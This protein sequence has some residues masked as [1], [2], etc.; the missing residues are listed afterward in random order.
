MDIKNQEEASISSNNKVQQ[1]REAII[2]AGG[3]GTRLKN[4]VP[5]LPK[6]LANVAGR[7]F[8][9]YVINYL[10]MQ[11]IEKIIFSLGYKHDLILSW[12][13][14]AYPTLDYDYVVEAAPLGT[15]GAI[16]FALEKTNTENILV[17]NG[18][19]LYNFNA[20]ALYYQHSNLKSDCT[21]A[22]KPMQ[23]FDRYGVVETN[24][25]N[26]IT[27]F[28]EKQFY[29]KGFI[30]AGVYLINKKKFLEKEFPKIFSFEKNYLERFV[31][32]QKFSGYVDD[33][34]FIDIGIPEDYKKAQNE[35][36][37][38]NL[39]FKNIDFGWTLFLD[40]DGVI[41]EDKPG[42]YITTPQEFVFTLGAPYLFKT[43][44]KK[45]KRIIVVTNQRGVGRGIIKYADLEA[46]HEKMKQEI[47]DTGGRI[48]KIYF[49]TDVE[50][51]SICR[52]PNP[53]MALRALEDFPKID[54]KKSIMVGNSLSDMK[55]GRY[56][57]MFTVF[58]QSTNKSISQPNADIDLIFE[59]LYDFTSALK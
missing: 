17:T 19:T 49:C 15:G 43:L 18:D 53:G 54:F 33:V 26:V 50:D 30:N 41:N 28:K 11:G 32:D 40:R 35:L 56:A 13:Q 16:Q 37:R 20:S 22:L 4:A 3:L 10:R 47:E 51:I 24:K 27:S 2:L 46:M 14:E 55:F 57:G 45:F 23:D 12:L 44:S 5:D 9:Y 42:G 8:L 48:D 38:N 29:R 59:N 58:I 21:L 25:R 7:P 6:C 36:A 52:K 31:S 1:K 34:Y 39:N